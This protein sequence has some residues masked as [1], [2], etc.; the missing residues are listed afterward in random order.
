MK[1]DYYVFEYKERFAVNYS[2]YAYL[3]KSDGTLV[4]PKIKKLFSC[5]GRKIAF[6]EGDTAIER[7]RVP[8][9]KTIKFGSQSIRTYKFTDEVKQFDNS[10]PAYDYVYKA[11]VL[12]G[13]YY[14]IRAVYLPPI[15]NKY[16]NA[17]RPPVI[18]MSRV[19]IDK[20]SDGEWVVADEK[21][22]TPLDWM[23][24][25]FDQDISSAFLSGVL[26]I[27]EE[28]QRVTDE[29]YN[30]SDKTE[31][32][33]RKRMLKRLNMKLGHFDSLFHF[34]RDYISHYPYSELATIRNNHI[35]YR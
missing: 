35:F 19:T 8:H 7:V 27:K 1:P 22:D 29:P 4:S 9:A 23:C 34:W 6:N 12:A 15:V 28:I 30:A 31:T 5:A 16:D 32:E 20:N 11:N 21:L 18:R 10:I 13:D 24:S 2:V 33:L 26:T 25:N 3:F 17:V 14:W